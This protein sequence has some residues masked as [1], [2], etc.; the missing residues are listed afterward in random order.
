MILYTSDIEVIHKKYFG[1]SVIY[2]FISLFCIL[3]GAIYEL[4]SHEVYSYYMIYAFIFPLVCGTLLFSILSLIKIRV[5]P[6]V[7][8]R[9]LYHS[10]VAALTVGSIMQGILDIY[11]TTNMLTVWYWRAGLLFIIFSIILT[12]LA[13]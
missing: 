4:Y 9:N 10:G 1:K 13:R 5:Y 7:L 3:F 6:G 8:A 12:L 11:G 2:L